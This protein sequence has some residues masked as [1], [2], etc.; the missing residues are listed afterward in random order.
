MHN[1]TKH[2]NDVL[3]ALIMGVR[4]KGYEFVKV[5]ELI[6]TENYKLDHEGRQYVDGPA[7]T[8]APAI[9]SDNVGTR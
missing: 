6:Y 8:K 4:E 5:S 3:E 7:P 1:G 2:T 9:P